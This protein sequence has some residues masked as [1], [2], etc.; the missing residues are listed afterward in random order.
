LHL[1]GGAKKVILSAPS[2]D[3]DVKTIVLGVNDELI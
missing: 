1:V 3:E 2:P